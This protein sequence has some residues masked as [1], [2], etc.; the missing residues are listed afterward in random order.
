MLDR[1]VPLFASLNSRGVEYLV[2][3]GVAAIAHGVPR[4]TLDVDLLIRPEIAN[5][6]ALLA[7][8]LDV[9]LGTAAL[10]EPADLLDNEITVFR[11]RIRVDVQ[12]ATPGLEFADAYTRRVTAQVA[13]CAV[14]LVSRAD[15]VA[16]KRAAGR[17]QDL[18]DVRVL[19][20]Q[21]TADTAD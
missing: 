16:A 11:D 14:P 1:L 21:D 19:E 3:G 7:A 15:L 6:A 2:I 5:A 17:P 10:I 9:G 13:G 8:F 12:T 18:E 20:G 4:L